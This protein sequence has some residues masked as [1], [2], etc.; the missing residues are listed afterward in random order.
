MK[1]ITVDHEQIMDDA[2][3]ILMETFPDGLKMVASDGE[4]YMYVPHM[5][6]LVEQIIKL[7]AVSILDSIDNEEQLSIVMPS[8]TSIH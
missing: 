1:A 8:S 7:T 5:L 2:L 3:E 6:L 4:E